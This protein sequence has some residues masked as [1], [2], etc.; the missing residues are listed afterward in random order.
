MVVT[1]RRLACGG[2]AF[3]LDIALSPAI[4]TGVTVNFFASSDARMFPPSA[5]RS[6][7]AG[8]RLFGALLREGVFIGVFMG[9]SQDRLKFPHTRAGVKP[10][11]ASPTHPELNIPACA[12]IRNPARRSIRPSVR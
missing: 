7:T 3:P 4:P 11:Q 12:S 5:T 1:V 2:R 8:G 10:R 9:A 6:L